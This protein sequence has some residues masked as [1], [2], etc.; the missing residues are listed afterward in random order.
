[1]SGASPRRKWT[2]AMTAALVRWRREGAS[3]GD[4]AKRLGVTRAIA[5]GKAVFAGLARRGLRSRAMSE[6]RV[7]PDEPEP[8]GALREVLAQGLCH[9]IRGDALGDWRMCGHPSVHGG[10]WCGHHLARV[11]VGTACPSPSPTSCPSPSGRRWIAA[12]RGETHEGP[13]APES[14]IRHGADA[15]R[16]LLPEGEGQDDKEREWGGGGP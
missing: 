7:L 1:M 15:P 8:L 10:A 5:V 16:H 12:E 4:I 13:R 3:F 11:Y 9:W 6:V 14:L 2:R